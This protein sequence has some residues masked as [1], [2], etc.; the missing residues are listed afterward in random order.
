MNIFDSLPDE[1]I[2]LIISY[3]EITNAKNFALT[4]K[5]MAD[6]ATTRLWSKPFYWKTKDLDFL[7]KIS[8]FPI[9]EERSVSF[10]NIMG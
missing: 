1:I 10:S 3:L 8:K 6:L 7:K 2:E 4:S 5:K 9:R